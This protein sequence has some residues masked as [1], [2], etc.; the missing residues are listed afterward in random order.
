MRTRGAGE[1]MVLSEASIRSSS[2]L[3][4]SCC[5]SDH[6]S[7][8]GQTRGAGSEF[9]VVEHAVN[10]SNIGRAIRFIIDHLVCQIGIGLHL[11][12]RLKQQ[13]KNPSENIEYERQHATRQAEPELLPCLP[14][15]PPAP[16]RQGS[17]SILP[18]QSASGQS[19]PQIRQDS[20]RR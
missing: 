6:V 13:P 12:L 9:V 7:R 4:R 11:S 20:G 19:Y 8:P 1:S 2:D 3:A 15:L 18:V 10:S 16:S 14:N 17:R 5:A